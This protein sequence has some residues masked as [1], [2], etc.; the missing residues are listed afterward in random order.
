MRLKEIEPVARALDRLR[1]QPGREPRHAGCTMPGGTDPDKIRAQLIVKAFKFA[2][3]QMNARPVEV[4]TTLFDVLSDA[5]KRA[6]LGIINR[7]EAALIAQACE[8]QEKK[9]QTES[10][11]SKRRAAIWAALDAAEGE[12]STEL[13]ARAVGVSPKTIRRYREEWW[14]IRT[15]PSVA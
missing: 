10:E 13:L 1:A 7:T 8:V 3:S 6:V 11:L 2:G 5:D 9:K 12:I 4:F 14:E 15:R